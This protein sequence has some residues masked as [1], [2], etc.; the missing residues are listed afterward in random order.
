MKKLIKNVLVGSLIA[1]AAALGGVA[2]VYSNRANAS[3]EMQENQKHVLIATIGYMGGKP[4]GIL[5][6]RYHQEEPNTVILSFNDSVACENAKRSLSAHYRD[7][8][9]N[10][11]CIVMP[12]S[13]GIIQ[14]KS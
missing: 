6:W 13:G 12:A 8:V 5:W 14:S 1:G 3:I 7:S 9:F 11:A 4:S 10:G 2:T